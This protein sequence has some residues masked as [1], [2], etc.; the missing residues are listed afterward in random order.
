MRSLLTDAAPQ[1]REWIEPAPEQFRGEIMP[2]RRAAVLRQI[3]RHWPIVAADRQEPHGAM[4]MLARHSSAEEADV[5]RADPDQGGRFHYTADGRALN[6]MRGRGNLPG[7]L[8]GLRQQ[9]DAARPY[10]M[11][12]QGLISERYLP[13]FARAHPMPFVPETAEPR[14]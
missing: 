13:G 14:L 9:E 12:V 3:A 10:A 5:L 8:A 11:A 7:L 4:D 6:F 2:L 1:V